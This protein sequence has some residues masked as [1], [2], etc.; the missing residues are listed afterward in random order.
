MNRNAASEGASAGNHLSKRGIAAGKGPGSGAGF[1]ASAAFESLMAE[2][3][4][5]TR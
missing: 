4:D 1:S 2:I 3:A 5:I